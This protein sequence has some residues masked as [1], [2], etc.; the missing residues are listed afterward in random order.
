MMSPLAMHPK[1]WASNA[2]IALDHECPTRTFR[3]DQN[4]L[5]FTSHGIKMQLETSNRCSRIWVS[6][7]YCLCKLLCILHIGVS[8]DNINSHR[9]SYH[10]LTGISII[11]TFLLLVHTAVINQENHLKPFGILHPTERL[12]NTKCHNTSLQNRVDLSTL[13]ERWINSTTLL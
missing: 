8:Y 6:F 10:T 2:W 5:T 12:L 9:N 7:V 11:N 3:H 13:G 4:S 1:M